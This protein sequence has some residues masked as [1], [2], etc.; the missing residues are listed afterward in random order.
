M[1]DINTHNEESGKHLAAIPKKELHKAP[2]GYFDALPDQLL[3]RIKEAPVFHGL[4]K[5][6]MV[7]AP[8]HYFEKLAVNLEA[9]KKRGSGKIISIRKSVTR[10][11]IAASFALLIGIGGYRFFFSNESLNGSTEITASTQ[12]FEEYLMDE[13]SNE[14]LVAYLDE[15]NPLVQQDD[16]NEVIDYLIENESELEIENL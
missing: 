7:S 14:E 9:K 10:W 5:K 6:E 15:V 4:E 3:N 13:V 2:E 11:S 12:D 16:N 8:D 1:K